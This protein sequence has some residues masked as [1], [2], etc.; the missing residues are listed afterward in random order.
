MLH[1]TQYR[2]FRRREVVSNETPTKSAELKRQQRLHDIGEVSVGIDYS[3]QYITNAR[4]LMWALSESTVSGVPDASFG[5]R[6]TMSHNSP[7]RSTRCWHVPGRNSR[8]RLA[9]GGVT[10]RANA[11]CLFH[12]F[13]ISAI[14]FLCGRIAVCKQ[15]NVLHFF[16]RFSTCEFRYTGWPKKVSHY[17]V[18]KNCI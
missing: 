16:A 13:A 14:A 10:G 17:Q 4:L 8:C 1:P 15:T 3:I 2:S 7:R 18:I 11:A 9:R 5:R 6:A 12:E